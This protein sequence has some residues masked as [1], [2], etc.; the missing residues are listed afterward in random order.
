MACGVDL[1]TQ[2]AL[3]IAQVAVGPDIWVFIFHYSGPGMSGAHL[4]FVLG[5]VGSWPVTS[6]VV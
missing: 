4:S 6:Y 3:A 1:K 2:H 5:R